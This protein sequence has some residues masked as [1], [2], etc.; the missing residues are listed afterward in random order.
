VNEIHKAVL[1]DKD[2]SLSLFNKHAFKS[3]IPQHEY[4][5][6]SN[7]IINSVGGLPLAI[8]V[9]GS[10]LCGRTMVEWKGAIEKLKKHSANR[11]ILGVLKISF[12]GLEHNEQEIFLD[13]ACFFIGKKKDNVLEILDSFDFYPDIGLSVLVEKCLLNI[14]NGTLQMHDM[15]KELAWDIVYQ[16]D[17]KEPG[18]RSRLWLREDVQAVLTNDTW[19]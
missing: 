10:F 1:L 8:R 12:D 19:L 18:R 15:I 11:E 3:N 6:P 9:L 2:E 14:V 7:V 17:P 4:V 5:E 16:M 13:I